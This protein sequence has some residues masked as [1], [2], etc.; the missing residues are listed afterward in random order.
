MRELFYEDNEYAIINL[1]NGDCPTRFYAYATECSEL[2]GNNT[3]E[4]SNIRMI[5]LIN[6]LFA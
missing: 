4:V 1:Y 3:D 5:L 2:F 6:V